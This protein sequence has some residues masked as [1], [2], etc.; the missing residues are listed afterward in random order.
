MSDV[1]TS[2]DVGR[3]L[4]LWT[5]PLPLDEAA[6][7]AA[8]REVY[9]DPVTVNGA[10]LTAADL[11]G[12]ARILQAAFDRPEAEVLSVADAGAAVAIAFRL[13][14]RHVGAVDTPAG[15]LPAS[16]RPIHVEI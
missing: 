16:G 5:D 8:F 7:A 12:R 15:R 1:R 13:S 6:A 2:F 14:G 9:A 4:R 3:L 10:R 11:V